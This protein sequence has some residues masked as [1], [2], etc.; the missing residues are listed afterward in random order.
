MLA[1]GD[2]QAQVRQ[3]ERNG[4]DPLGCL[5]LVT[6]PDIRPDFGKRDGQLFVDPQ[7]ARNRN[8]AG[9]APIAYRRMT[10]SEQLGQFANPAG[11]YDDLVYRHC[12]K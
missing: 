3:R 2:R 9:P 12:G 10:D 8:A 1:H 7:S 11:L 6:R 5:R 4:Y